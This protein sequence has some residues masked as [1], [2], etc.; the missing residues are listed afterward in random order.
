MDNKK[1]RLPNGNT[2]DIF[3][4]YFDETSS[5]SFI[6][7]NLSDVI[8]FF[9]NDI[10]DYIDIVNEY[11]DVV[12]SHRLN[13]KYKT[14]TIEDRDIVTIGKRLVKKAYTELIEYEDEDGNVVNTEEVYH[15]E[16]IEDVENIM[17]K[18]V[19]TVFLS[20]PS[21]SEEIEMIKNTIG[22]A[23]PNNMSLEEFK[24]YKKDVIGK[25]CEEIINSGVDVEING[26][27]KHFSYEFRDQLDFHD[28]MFCAI[29][30]DFS[31]ML[32]W[33]SDGNL[34]DVYSSIDILRIYT[35]LT[36][37]KMYYTTYCNILND[38][39]NKAEDMES[40]KAIT[41]GMDVSNEYKQ[42]LQSIM[43]ASSVIINSITSKLNPEV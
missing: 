24:I 33:H 17:R 7:A 11:G 40:V 36:T 30:G 35:E 8:S 23:N 4:Y 32:P 29:L 19:I 22:I 41:F 3:D 34:C 27:M 21:I 28:L 16:V 5:F 2:I 25:Q 38:M 1:L 13:A 15:P 43:N 20:K 10:I 39:I 37:N 12:A 6:D 31:L 14:A 26:D 9:G 18:T 42:R